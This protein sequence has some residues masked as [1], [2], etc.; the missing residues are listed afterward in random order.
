MLFMNYPSARNRLFH[1]FVMTFHMQNVNE[2]GRAVKYCVPAVIHSFCQDMWLLLM[3]IS[4]GIYMNWRTLTLQN[5]DFLPFDHD[6]SGYTSNASKPLARNAIRKYVLD[7]AAADGH[8]LQY[9][10]EKQ[11]VHFAALWTTQKL[12]SYFLFDTQSAHF[13]RSSWISTKILC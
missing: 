3:N 9:E 8:P 6:L 5:R 4:K 13:I 12:L 10:C 2:N 1:A 11:T 7:I